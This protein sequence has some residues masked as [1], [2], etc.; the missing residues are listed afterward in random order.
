M[1]IIKDKSECCGCESC[2]QACPTQCISPR[3]DSEGFIYPKVDVSKC[4]N[5]GLCERVCPQLLEENSRK[6]IKSLAAINYSKEV[7]FKS[8]SGGVF[9]AI[10][11]KVIEEG[12]I[13]FGACFDENWNVVH[14]R[15]EEVSEL[16]KLRSSKYVQSRIDTT[17]AEVREN[18][19]AGRQVLFSGTPCQVSGLKLFLRKP[20]SNLLTIEVACHGVPSP[21]VWDTYLKH[22]IDKQRI[23]SIMFR[24]KSRGWENY[25]LKITDKEN[26]TVYKKGSIYDPYMSCFLRNISIRPSCFHCNSKSGRS[27]ADILLG[28]LW[29]CEEIAP[30]F[31]DNKGTSLVLV[32]SENGANWL[33]KCKI[34]S[35]E[36]DYEIAISRNNAIVRSV[37]HCSERAVFWNDFKNNTSKYNIIE[38]Y[39]QSLASTRLQLF[40][41][42]VYKLYKKYL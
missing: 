8:S 36:I 12:G 38:R 14:A 22:K 26:R 37:P 30:D 40:K 5:C 24:D 25:Q 7:R 18:L 20:Y 34:N 6:P 16:G 17:F 31:F 11:C 1:L 35:D 29:G 3:R 13:V 28:D 4:I 2:I 27:G 23:G 10:A 19:R 41:T 21:L 32:Y 33:N 15:V 39:G 42:A 9:T